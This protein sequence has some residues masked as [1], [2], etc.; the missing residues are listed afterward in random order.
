MPIFKKV[1]GKWVFDAEAPLDCDCGN[2]D[3]AKEKALR[4]W[5]RRNADNTD[6]EEVPEG[7]HT[8]E[9]SL[10]SKLSKAADPVAGGDELASEGGDGSAS[11]RKHDRDESEWFGL[12]FGADQQPNTLAR[13]AAATAPIEGGVDAAADGMKLELD[14][15]SDATEQGGAVST[16]TPA[17]ASMQMRQSWEAL[18][19]EPQLVSLLCQE[20]VPAPKMAGSVPRNFEE[21]AHEERILQLYGPAAP[22][23]LKEA[24][25]R[26]MARSQMQAERA[27]TPALVPSRL[28]AAPMFFSSEGQRVPPMA[29]AVVEGALVSAEQLEAAAR[30]KEANLSVAW[31]F[32]GSVPHGYARFSA[33]LVGRVPGRE[34]GRLCAEASHEIRAGVA[35]VCAA[36]SCAAT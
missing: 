32:A 28:E 35:V 15:S 21:L 2:P 6:W 1:E 14:T 26:I 10:A 17:P 16:R 33:G 29:V 31:C 30:L 22:K 36:G 8:S 23:L 7:E 34:E 5:M 20:G 4:P 19:V 13:I 27:A 11:G 12:E 25:R 9:P 3:C 18:G 24:L